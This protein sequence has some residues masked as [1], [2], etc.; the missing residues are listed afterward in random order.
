MG[1]M[2]K[3]F[4]RLSR[5]AV[6]QF[7]AVLTVSLGTVFPEEVLAA[8]LGDLMPVKVGNWWTYKETSN[9]KA[10][11]SKD[12]VTVSKPIHDGSVSF[13]IVS[14]GGAGTKRTSSFKKRDGRVILELMRTEP[15]GCA[16]TFS[17]PK[18]F[19]DS[20]VKAGCIWK[21]SGLG[22][23]KEETE[24]WQVFPRET[25]TVPAGKFDCVRV[26]G[27]M[28]R[29]AEVLYQMRW[30][31]PGVGLVK[32]SEARGSKKTTF[33]LSGYHVR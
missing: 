17:P 32:S 24:T 5:S 4:C 11:I 28:R 31:S 18:L 19:I 7:A 33:E 22:E 2:K 30:F 14:T 23:F 27:L 1:I 9:P 12:L 10:G 13:Q 20:N 21:W 16:R 26:G 3:N 6:F 15:D 8:D 25:I 29:G